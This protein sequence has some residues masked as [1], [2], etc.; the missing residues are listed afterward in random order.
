[1]TEHRLRLFAVDPKTSAPLAH[2]LS[3]G[4]EPSG[5]RGRILTTQ[6][7]D[8]Q[9]QVMDQTLLAILKDTDGWDQSYWA[10]RRPSAARADQSSQPMCGTSFCYAGHSAV[11]V[12][13]HL[14][15]WNLD[16]DRSATAAVVQTRYPGSESHRL[17]ISETLRADQGLSTDQISA[18]THECNSLRRLV[19]LCWLFSAGQVNRF[20]D[21]LALPAQFRFQDAVA[22]W[23]QGQRLARSAEV[24]AER[25]VEP[26]AKRTQQWW[27]Q[28][29]Y[30]LHS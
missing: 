22:E 8:A 1:M 20:D 14:P 5:P 26:P 16:L 3:A 21:Y 18:I 29:L 27:E 9:F 28:Q 30:W 11:T 15:V 24:I 19:E 13:G 7:T 6:M 23:E 17:M 10:F 12:M 4:H 2:T 25:T